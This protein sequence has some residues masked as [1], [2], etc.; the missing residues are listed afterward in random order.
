MGTTHTL[1]GVERPR[2]TLPIPRAPAGPSP[3][4]A[5]ISGD[6]IV[7]VF[8]AN[9]HRLA[10]RPALRRRVGEEW[11]ILTWAGYG[12]QVTEIAAGLI[13]A[14]V[15]PG[16]R[17][18]ILSGNRVEWHVADLAT[19]SCAAVTVPLYPTSSPE[20]VAYLLRHAQARVCFVENDEQL[21]KV[22]DVLAS[23][24]HLEHVVVFETT[25]QEFGGPSVVDF[26]GLRAAGA[27]RV[28][29]EPGLVDARSAAIMPE[30][31]ATLVYTSGTTGPPKGAMVTHSNVMW[32]VRSA[33]SRIDAREGERFLSFLPLSHIAER[34]MSDFGAIALGGETWFARSLATVAADLSDCR[35]TVFF[36]VPRVWE[37][38]HD[39][40]LQTLATERGASK[41]AIDRYLSLGAAIVSAADAGRPAPFWQRHAYQVLDRV[42]GTKIRH[43][44]GLDQAH[45]MITAAA[46]IHPDLIRWFHAVGLPV[47]ELYGQT[48]TCGPTT[49]NTN[50]ENRIGTVGHPIPGVT[51]QIAEDGEILV[52]GGNVCT[53]YFADR[54]STAALID[55]DGWMH[56]GD[57][58]AVEPDGNL[59]I[60]GRKKD[61]IITAAGQNIAPQEIELDLRNHAL[62]SEAVVIGEGHRYLTALLTLD[63]DALSAWAQANGRDGGYEALADDP[64]VHR[65]VDGIVADVNSRRSRVENVR[66]YRILAHEW[67]IAAGELTPTGKVKRNVVNERYASVIEAMYAEEPGAHTA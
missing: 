47:F 66:R 10:D 37:K 43:E 19:L 31:L 22:L 33:V 45:I 25:S 50:R 34:M 28:L 14:G 32:T 40:V 12:R 17:V 67:T 35:P 21:G 55:T 7:D 8:R 46:P 18:A 26:E 27:A 6:T 61:L 57:L 48:E 24:P 64:D 52:K 60:T 63:G 13:G 65:L 42:V 9:I 53:G 4:S 59:R 62:I 49:S 1:S 11:E 38:F 5:M 56:S 44:L 20:Q 23:L 39:A 30:D 15:E 41:L 16:N 54:A 36:A 3:G 58:G 2:A 29:R 51:L